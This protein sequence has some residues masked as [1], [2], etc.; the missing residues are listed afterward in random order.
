MKNKLVIDLADVLALVIGLVVIGDRSH[1]ESGRF[2]AWALDVGRLLAVTLDIDR[3]GFAQIHLLTGNDQLHECQF[4][5]ARSLGKRTSGHFKR[6]RFA[7]RLLSG[8]ESHADWSDGIVSLFGGSQIIIVSNRYGLV[9]ILDRHLLLRSTSCHLNIGDHRY[10][11]FARWRAVLK[12]ESQCHRFPK[13]DGVA[14]QSGVESRRGS[15]LPTAEHRHAKQDHPPPL[16]AGR[17]QALLLRIL[18]HKQD[19]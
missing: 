5:R 13:G 16:R 6:Q 10:F 9:S 7:C 11:R 1:A 12:G 18:H 19:N 4:R 3:N 15:Q 8:V 2:Q 17:T 14:I